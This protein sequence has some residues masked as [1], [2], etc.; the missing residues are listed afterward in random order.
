MLLR[1]PSELSFAYMSS[2]DDRLDEDDDVLLPLP[3]S[4]LLIF[5]MFEFSIVK[6]FIFIFFVGL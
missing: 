4:P 1:A 6:F 2:N 3:S 5:R